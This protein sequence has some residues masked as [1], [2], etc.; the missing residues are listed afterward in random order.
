M[1][2]KI[3]GALAVV[4]AGVLFPPVIMPGSDD[5]L[6]VAD[7]KK[8]K[9]PIPFTKKSIA[10]GRSLY[11]RASCT[12]CHGADGKATVDV[13]ADATDLTDP[14]LWK[15]GTTE[16]EIYRSIRDGEGASMP[17]FKTQL[18]GEDDI[19]RL[20]NFIRSLWPESARPPLQEDKAK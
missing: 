11:M 6:S 1:K 4:L 20:V 8:L 18:H 5:K 12:G 9:S 19:W 17:A 7:A 3:H 10:E 2:L 14:T 15:N 16:G 13:V